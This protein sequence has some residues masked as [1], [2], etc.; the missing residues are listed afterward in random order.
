MET[1]VGKIGGRYIFCI[2]SRTASAWLPSSMWPSHML[3]GLPPHTRTHLGYKPSRPYTPVCV[4]IPMQT[5]NN[6]VRPLDDLLGTRCIYGV[7]ARVSYTCPTS[8]CRSP[9][10]RIGPLEISKLSYPSLPTS[11]PLSVEPGM[12]APCHLCDKYVCC[13]YIHIPEDEVRGGPHSSR[14]PPFVSPALGEKSRKMYVLISLSLS[15][16]SRLMWVMWCRSPHM[17]HAWA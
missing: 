16:V 17:W 8:L 6:P 5:F 4:C 12:A 9:A 11:M 2:I 1:G 15:K 3:C 14:T 10:H 13:V 7:Y